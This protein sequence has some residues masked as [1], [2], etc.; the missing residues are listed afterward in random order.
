M[1]TLNDTKI[2]SDLGRIVGK[3][4]VLHQPEEIIAYTTDTITRELPIKNYHAIVFP[5]STED[6]VK[7]MY[8]V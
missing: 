8:I 4:N 5:Q 3:N 2:V 6:I 7:I 1:A